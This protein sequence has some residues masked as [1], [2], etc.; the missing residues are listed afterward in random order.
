MWTQSHSAVTRINCLEV[1]REQPNR[2]ST[3]GRDQESCGRITG[4]CCGRCTPMSLPRP[5][6][7]CGRL[8]NPS[9]RC[10]AHTPQTT[11][12][13]GYGWAHQRRRQR[14]TQLV[15][16]GQ[17]VCVRCGRRIPPGAEWDLDHSDNRATWLGPSCRRCNRATS[18][19]GRRR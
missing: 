15:E 16:G 3:C 7:T 12:Q 1:A 9:P 8:T 14:I 18:S 2:C 6:L 4:P 11:T 19:K 10:P 5:C 13:R 17:A